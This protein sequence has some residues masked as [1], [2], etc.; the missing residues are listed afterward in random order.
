MASTCNPI[1]GLLVFGGMALAWWAMRSTWNDVVTR[2]DRRRKA[3]ASARIRQ[4]PPDKLSGENYED[5]VAEEARLCRLMQHRWANAD[6]EKRLAHVQ[7]A[8]M[9]QL[10]GPVASPAI[11]KSNKLIWPE[12]A[13]VPL[14]RKSTALAVVTSKCEPSKRK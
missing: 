7:A 5:L 10:V 2:N 14:T 8:I 6:T 12:L 3:S 13:P 11:E 4:L 1:P 9:E